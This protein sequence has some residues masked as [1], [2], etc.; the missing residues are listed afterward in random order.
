MEDV[1]EGDSLEVPDGHLASSD[2][3]LEPQNA[4]DLEGHSDL[5]A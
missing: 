1:I 4:P 5:V 2:R 3:Q